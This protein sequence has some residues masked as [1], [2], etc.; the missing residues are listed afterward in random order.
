M[1]PQK[2]KELREAM[3]AGRLAMTAATAERNAA[4]ARR[5]WLALGGSEATFAKVNV[6]HFAS[7]N[8]Q[9][10]RQLVADMG[11]TNEQ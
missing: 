2:G 9:Q 11:V 4:D 8:E 10:Q 1:D 3:N 6:T 7:M 5:R